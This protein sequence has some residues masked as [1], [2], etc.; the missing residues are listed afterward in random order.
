MAGKHGASI[1]DIAG[2][3]GVPANVV[4]RVLAGGNGIAE[5]ERR[6]VMGAAKRAGL[7]R[8]VRLRKP[9]IGI[10]VNDPHPSGFPGAAAVRLNE[11]VTNV[12]MHDY[13]VELFT[14]RT[15]A[16]V[17]NSV[18]EGIVLMDLNTVP[19]SVTSAISTI[20]TVAMNRSDIAGAS[21]VTA[22]HY[23][24]GEMAMRHLLEK[25]HRSVAIVSSDRDNWAARQRA[26]GFAAEAEKSDEEANVHAVW[27][28]RPSV[29]SVLRQLIDRHGP[30]AIFFSGESLLPEGSYV[31][32]T[33]LGKRIP[34][35]ISV[36]GME[37]AGVTQFDSPAITAIAP[38]KDLAAES[39]R[40][41]VEAMGSADAQPQ[42]VVLRSTLIRRD[43]V[44]NRS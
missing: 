19:D 36:I 2:A 4:R 10:V 7:K 17:A 32:R 15:A 16:T 9:T 13:A 33:A 34:E 25:G 22:N 1:Y 43:S 29:D 41:L 27:A 30:T 23:E 21:C 8:R 12:A 31:L 28:D 3:T 11:L 42:R 18:I 5:A 44:L 24:Q 40:L 39:V 35:D 20:P 26:S 6:R 14:Q 38:P 37:S